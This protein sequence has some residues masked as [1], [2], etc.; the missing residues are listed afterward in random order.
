MPTPSSYPAA[1]EPG[2]IELSHNQ[3]CPGD[4]DPRDFKI[5]RAGALGHAQDS[6]DPEA[7]KRSGEHQNRNALPRTSVDR[8]DTPSYQQA[9]RAKKE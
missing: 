4:C 9:A 5:T 6:N 8:A 3:E 7:A 1:R 2:P